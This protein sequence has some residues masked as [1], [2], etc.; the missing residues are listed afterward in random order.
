MAI[1]IDIY[2][3]VSLD[4]NISDSE[5]EYLDDKIENEDLKPYRTNTLKQKYK[6]QATSKKM[7]K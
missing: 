4:M 6:C 3:E 1:K 7:A 2:K 5:A